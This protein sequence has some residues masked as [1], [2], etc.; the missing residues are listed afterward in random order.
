MKELRLNG[1]KPRVMLWAIFLLLFIPTQ[2]MN[3]WGIFPRYDQWT[4]I[5]FPLAY[6]SYGE[7]VA[8]TYFNMIFFVIDIAIFYLVAWLAVY[9]HRHYTKYKVVERQSGS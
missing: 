3:F 8:Y 1:L 6:F 2:L 4:D 9:F 7:A 5:G